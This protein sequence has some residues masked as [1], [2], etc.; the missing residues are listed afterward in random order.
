M[1]KRRKQ[2]PLLKH[3]ALR[4]PAPPAAAEPAPAAPPATSSAPE[5]PTFVVVRRSGPLSRIALAA[6]GS[7]QVAAQLEDQELAALERRIQ[8]IQEDARAR[9]VETFEGLREA[10]G[11][12]ASA[13]GQWLEA[14]TAEDGKGLVLEL[15]APA[16]K[17]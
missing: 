12:P 1:S 3:P 2:R 6:L 17:A 4:P 10:M 15:R 13:E 16:P 9:Q 11:F 8:R 7:H 14:V 5:A